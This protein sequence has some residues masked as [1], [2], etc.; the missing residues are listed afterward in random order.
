MIRT[1]KFQDARAIANIYNEYI[2][3]SVI[4]FETEPL[5]LQEMQSRIVEI[6][7]H[8]PYYVYEQ[9]DGEILGYCYAHLWKEREAYKHTLE[10]TVYLSPEHK[11]KGIGTSLMQRLIGECCRQGYHA[12][13]ACITEGNEASILMHSSTVPCCR[14]KNRIA[15]SKTCLM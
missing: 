10:T 12:L 5:S 3:H 6:S 4:S 14:S 2:K 9:Q 7:A 11:G 1:V 15:C 8:F 13:I